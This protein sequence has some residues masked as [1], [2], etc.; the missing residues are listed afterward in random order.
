MSVGGLLRFV[1]VLSGRKEARPTRGIEGGRA[2]PCH[3]TQFNFI[4]P[5]FAAIAAAQTA[6]RSP[7]RPHPALG[8]F[9]PSRASGVEDLDVVDQFLGFLPEL[10]SDHSFYR[11]GNPS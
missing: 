5:D 2:I 1:C 8:S 11:I 7:A 10:T 6:A 3:K 9:P 4:V